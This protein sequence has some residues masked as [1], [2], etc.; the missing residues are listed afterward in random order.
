MSIL[1][2]QAKEIAEKSELEKRLLAQQFEES[3]ARTS[4]FKAAT[5][6]INLKIG[7]PFDHS[8]NED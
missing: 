8:F 4:Y 7:E 6:A 1:E 2:Y 5:K 3:A